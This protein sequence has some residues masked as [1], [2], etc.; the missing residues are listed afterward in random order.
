MYNGI[1][2]EEFEGRAKRIGLK[3]KHTKGDLIKLSYN[4]KQIATVYKDI[5]VRLLNDNYHTLP[6]E[7][8]DEIHYITFWLDREQFECNQEGDK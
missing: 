4:G 1:T 2:L 6:Q 5:K 8:R 7:M 3:I